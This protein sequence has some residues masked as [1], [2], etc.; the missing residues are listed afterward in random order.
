MQI[1]VITS[2]ITTPDDCLRFSTDSVTLICTESAM[3][4]KCD[5][6]I[7]LILICTYTWC[8]RYIMLM[9]IIVLKC[10]HNTW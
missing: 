7:H 4:S 9:A 6:T 2:V 8:I 10:D 1:T 3:R 5:K